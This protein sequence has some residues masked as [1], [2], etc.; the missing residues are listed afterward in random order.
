MESVKIIDGSSDKSKGEIPNLLSEALSVS[1]DNHVG[2]DYIDDVDKR[3][4]MYHRQETKI[5]FDLELF[6]RITDGG[7]SNKTLNIALAGTGVGK[8][9]FMC[10]LAASCLYRGYDVLYITLEMAEEKIAERI[11]ANLLNVNIKDLKKISEDEY[12]KRFSKLKNKASGRLIIKEYPTA[13]ASTL[14]FR[15]LLNDLK[16]K[17]RFK[18][19][20]IFIDYL[21]ICCS[22]R[23]KQGVNT[24]SYTYIKSI[25]EEIRGL[26]V[27]FNVPI[28]SATQTNRT[29]YTSSDPGLEDTSE[30]IFINEQVTL[31]DGTVKKICDVVPGDQVISNDDYKTVMFVHHKKVKDCV[32][33]TLKSGRSLI[34][35]K[36]HIFPT[37]NGR[38]CFNTGLVVGD[39]LNSI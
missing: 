26:A 17:K 36:D 12:N 23:L 22:S 2:H 29:G 32:K 31:V 7:V 39:Y 1:F 30:C 4:E 33:V 24:N 25:A 6:N 34:V 8:S 19:Q 18:P 37:K 5:P 10:H 15:A 35:S 38:K 11:D 14:H 20:I 13:S 3:F 28:F 21:N 27:E 16:L 9:L